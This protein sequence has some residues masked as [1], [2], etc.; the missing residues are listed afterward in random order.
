MDRAKGTSW[1][2]LVSNGGVGCCRFLATLS[3]FAIALPVQAAPDGA[4][5]LKKCLDLQVARLVPSGDTSE[6][7][8]RAALY[9]C[10]NELIDFQTER[11]A[12]GGPEVERLALEASITRA[13]EL[14]A[15]QHAKPVGTAKPGR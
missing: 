10:R 8:G 1:A 4:D 15:A 9:K 3:F 14:K 6:I 5:G 12:L 13:V 2:K 7:V 11:G